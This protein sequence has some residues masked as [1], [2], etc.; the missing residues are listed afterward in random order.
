MI[1]T[2][3]QIF[4]RKL[5]TEDVPCPELGEGAKLI[6]RRLSTREYLALVEKANAQPDLIYAHY[7]AA[8]VVDE[9]GK[10]VFTADD[11][12]ALADQDFE[13]VNRLGEVAI[14]LNTPTKG[15]D[16]KNSQT[17]H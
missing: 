5:P 16:G 8:A 10:Q 9:G 4:S 14:R 17:T 12:A 2:R 7:I 1:P 13:L 11:A 15:P 3:E 6:V